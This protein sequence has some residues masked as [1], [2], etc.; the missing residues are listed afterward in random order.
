M[1]ETLAQMIMGKRKFFI[2]LSFRLDTRSSAC[3]SADSSPICRQPFIAFDEHH[4]LGGQTRLSE[5]LQVGELQSH[6]DDMLDAVVADCLIVPRI[7]I[8]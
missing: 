1:R 8:R 2:Q 4:S 5:A 7:F 6:T 3:V